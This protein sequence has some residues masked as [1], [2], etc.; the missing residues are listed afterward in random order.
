MAEA[1]LLSIYAIGIILTVC[2]LLFKLFGRILKKIYVGLITIT[3]VAVDNA[4]QRSNVS[5]QT[6][7]E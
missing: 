5:I 3:V 6:K 1:I 7:G 4:K 2:F